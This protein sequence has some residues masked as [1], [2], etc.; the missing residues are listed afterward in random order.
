[1][2]IGPIPATK[3]ALEKA[4]LTLDDMDLIELHADFAF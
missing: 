3:M 1:M 4:G 2:G